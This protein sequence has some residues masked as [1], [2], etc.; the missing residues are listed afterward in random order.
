M[1]FSFDEMQQ[2]AKE[3]SR[4]IL[5]DLVDEAALKAAERGPWGCES[6]HSALAE[7]GLLEAV[8]DDPVVAALVL[9]EAGRTVAPVPLLEA[10]VSGGVLR[11]FGGAALADQIVDGASVITVALDTGPHRIR[12]APACRLEGDRINGTKPLVTHL[13]SAEQVL[14]S[15]AGQDGPVLALLDTAA[16][17][18]E[19]QVCTTGQTLHTL[20]LESVQVNQVFPAAAL[21]MALDR[22]DVGLCA[23]AHGV[24]ARALDLTARYTRERQQFGRPIGSF[25]AVSQRAAN[26]YIDLQSMDLTLLESAWC[27]SAG[28][29]AAAALAVA[30][31]WACEGV[32]RIT[33]T[34]QHLHGGMGFD[35]DYPLYRTYL[36]S[37]RLELQLGGANAQLSR[38]GAGGSAPVG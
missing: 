3:L 21:R 8:V 7:A 16:C 31:Y 25:Q 14:L 13:D 33:A 36:W 17:T 6:A 23:L 38:I 26:G 32:H 35:K 22:L 9:S 1:D 19:R 10:F 30:R 28:R 24:A 2:A 18:S 15:A 5:T 34:A 37:K 4:Q 27:L 29:D 11:A 20:T 12:S